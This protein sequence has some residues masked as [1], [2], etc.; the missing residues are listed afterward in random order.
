MCT[1][2][3]GRACG[4]LLMVVWWLI[5]EKPPSATDDRFSIEIE[6]KSWCWWFQRESKTARGIIAKGASRQSNFMWSIK[7]SVST[8]NQG[9]PL[10]RNK[11]A[12]RKMVP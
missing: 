6:F 10:L 2:R 5:L 8:L 9:Y 7:M 1:R 12:A 11:D 4:V 3:G